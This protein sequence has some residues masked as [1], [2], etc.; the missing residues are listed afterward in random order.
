MTTYSETPSR[1]LEDPVSNVLKWIL[2][3]VAVGSFALFAWATVLTYE[4]AAPQPDRFVTPGGAALM[5]AEGI[6]AGKAGFQKADLMDYGSLYGMGSYFGQDYTAFGLVRLAK[7]TE[8]NL[9]RSR[10]GTGFE[11]LPVD[12]QAEARDTMR[13][14]L[15]TVDLTQREVVI[16]EALAAAIGTL[17]TEMAN[18]LRIIDLTTGWTPA[19]SLDETEAAHT[20][21]FLIYSALT[22]VARRPDTT[23]SWTENWPYEPEVGNTPTT[24]TFMWTWISFCFTFFAFGGVLFI[25]EFWLNSP[26]EGPMDPLLASFRP[27]TESQRKMGK[28]FLVVAAV[29]LLQ[30]LAGTIMAHAYYDRRSFY[31]LDLHTILPFN[32]L[33][34]VHIQAPIIW[35]GV[36]WIGAGLFLAPAI[37][38]GREARGQGLLVDILFWVTVIIVAGAL[39]G[40]WLGIMGYMQ[41]AW[42]WFG[43]QGLSYIQ[44]GRAWQIG[45]FAGLLIWSTLMFRALWPTG[46]MLR[47]ATRQFWSG[48][49]GPE[50]LIWAATL[51]IAVLYVF[52]MIPLTGI[53]KSFTINDFWRWWVVHLWVEQSFEFFAAS[54]SAY[55]LMAV[56]LVSRQLAERAVFFQLILI[57]LGGVLGTGHHLYWAGGPSMWVPAGRSS[58]LCTSTVSPTP[59]A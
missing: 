38:G 15:Q 10:F 25:Y 23:W 19:Y 11:A 35:I 24:N 12:R 1:P 14:Q 8:E 30:I 49:I 47:H 17:R 31:G 21:E 51:N 44:L 37:A 4:R 26:D 36:G 29:L 9:A 43:N 6:L 13:Q 7:L 53:E 22:T 20:A 39:I 54:M 33:R 58:R 55:L 40:N 2:L 59:A 56:G 42:F 18:N 16:P 3:A 5:T 28:Y 57:F 46:E 32:F 34:D 45:F 50:N 48:R 52:G 41:H 27:L